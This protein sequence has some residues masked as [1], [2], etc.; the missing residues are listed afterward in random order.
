M[1]SMITSPKEIVVLGY[2]GSPTQRLMDWSY[3]AR[4][5]K[6][7]EV[8]FFW[9]EEVTGSEYLGDPVPGTFLFLSLLPI[10]HELMK[11]LCLKPSSL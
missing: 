1:T 3:L 10:G 11:P 2:E 7:Q 8:G 5:W 6:L 9:G 4:V